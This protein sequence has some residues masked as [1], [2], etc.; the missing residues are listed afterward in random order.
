MAVIRKR[1]EF[2]TEGVNVP[3]FPI[4]D[5]HLHLYDIDRLSYPWLAGHPRINKSH[6]PAASYPMWVGIMDSI[7]AVASE[8]EKRKLFRDNAIRVYRLS[9]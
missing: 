2:P 1:N 6:L 5:S 7:V 9:R 4:V 3:S 8:A